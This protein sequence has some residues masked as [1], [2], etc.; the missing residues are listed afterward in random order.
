MT[1]RCVQKLACIAVALAGVGGCCGVILSAVGAHLSPSPLLATAAEF[2]LIHAVATLALAGLALA[3]PQRGGWLLCGAALFLLG[4][5]LFCGDLSARALMNV[6][7][8]PM[9][10]PIGG[11][12]LILGWAL[13]AVAAVPALWPIMNKQ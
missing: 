1:L 3:A 9:A 10:A 2:L 5:L 4:S 13:V 12:A 8:F 7:L 6:K 11:A